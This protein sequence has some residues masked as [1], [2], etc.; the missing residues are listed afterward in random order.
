MAGETISESSFKAVINAPIEKVDLA[1]GCSAFPT[2][3]AQR[4]SPAHIAAGT[5]PRTAS[6]CPSMSG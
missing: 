4:C 5:A 3:K 6:A 2:P 1:S